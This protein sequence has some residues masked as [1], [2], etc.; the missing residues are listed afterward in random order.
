[1]ILITVISV[2]L[3]FFIIGAF[4]RGSYL[5][6]IL[7]TLASIGLAVLNEKAD[8]KIHKLGQHPVFNP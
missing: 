2:I 8:S 5:L 4:L 3:A 6:S 7:L 1:M